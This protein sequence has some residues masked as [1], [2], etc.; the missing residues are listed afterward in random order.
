MRRIASGLCLLVLLLPVPAFADAPSPR[1]RWAALAAEAVEK[2]HDLG[3]WCRTSKMFGLRAEVLEMVLLFDPDD[4]VAREA[5]RYERE[6]DGTWKR[7]PGYR[8]PRNYRRRHDTYDERRAAWRAWFGGEAALLLQAARRAGD[9]RL[10]DEVLQIAVRAVPDDASLR[11]AN[12]EVAV[13]QDGRRVWI[14]EESQRALENR[15]RYRALGRAAVEEVTPPTRGTMSVGEETSGVPWTG[16]LQGPHVRLLGEP[17]PRE[18]ATSFRYCEAT[19]PVFRTVF[20]VEPPTWNDPGRYSRGVTVYVFD[21]L[22]GG[23]AFLA[24]QSGVTERDA[25]FAASLVGTWIRG[26]PAFVVKSPDATSRLECAPRML[27][28]TMAYH[29]LGVRD[30][31]GWAAEGLAHYLTYLVAGTRLLNSVA[32]EDA[33]YGRPQGD[34]PTDDTTAPTADDW[35]TTGLALLHGEDKPDLHL[36]AGKDVNAI[37]KEEVLYGYCLTAYLVEGWPGQAVGFFRQVGDGEQVDMDRAAL[38][39]LGVRASTLEQRLLRWLE[40]TASPR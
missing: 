19:W 14:L 18:M 5:L 29:R 4:A 31:C 25:A 2:L 12:R 40:E 36:L 16:V 33:R 24:R 39:H 27:F 13:E 37:T 20:D 10:A 6:A 21:T 9:A 15:P 11:S 30:A 28:A 1:A 7:R 35:L 23:N 34:L 3:D 8:P 38:E 17:P 32:D 22:E 26:R